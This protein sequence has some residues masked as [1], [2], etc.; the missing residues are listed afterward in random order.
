[1]SKHCLYCYK[2]LDSGLKDF[3]PH[4][5]IEFFGTDEPPELG[6]NLEQMAELA[7]AVV[8]RHVTV[9]G[10]QPKLSLT[11]VKDI[12][13][14][15]SKGRLTIV[16]T[17]GGNYILKPPHE[18][19]PEM[20]QNEHL[21][22]RM[23]ESFGLPVVQS[24]LIRLLSG[25]LAYITKRID[26]TAEGEKIHML[27]MF[28]VLEAFDKYKGSMEKVG[29]AI[30]MYAENTMLDLL[31]FYELSIFCFL[32]GNNDMHLKNFSMVTR[33]DTWN[34][35]PAYDLIN[36]TIINPGDKEELALTLN[37]RKSKFNRTRFVEFGENLGLT[38]R[39]IDGVFK[40]LERNKEKAIELVGNSF[41]S[42]K[43][44][45]KYIAVL[46]ERYD[47]ISV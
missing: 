34:L 32:T 14:D 33:N 31:N 6:Y 21:T 35:A 46:N 20:P 11:L 10:V 26:R 17:L 19:Y 4:C 42:E 36:V 29:K 1:M 9:P 40:R 5:S 16:G 23:A 3:H 47:R 7:A 12:L 2:Q 13:A 37:A 44:K 41:L 25:E 39:Q 38:T 27:D 45:K 28:Q 22:M 15:G 18:D 24:S 43:F 8:Q 30:S